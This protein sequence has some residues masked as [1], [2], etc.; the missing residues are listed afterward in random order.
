MKD[1][2]FDKL[3]KEQMKSD[4]YIPEKIDKLFSD[5]E[6]NKVD[7]N[8]KVYKFRRYLKSV[9]IAACAMLVIFVGG[10]FFWCRFFRGNQCPSPS[11]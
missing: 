4:T 8:H 9:S 11:L 5:F 7:D 2:E 3:L 1:E 6:K 10:W